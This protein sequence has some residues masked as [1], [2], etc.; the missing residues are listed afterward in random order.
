MNIRG[1]YR[2]AGL[3][4]RARHWWSAKDRAAARIALQVLVH[5]TR[6]GYVF[7]VPPEIRYPRWLP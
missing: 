3:E 6:P 4:V 7:V 1:R 2:D 5:E